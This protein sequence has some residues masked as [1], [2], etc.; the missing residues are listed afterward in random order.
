LA[1]QNILGAPL[2]GGKSAGAPILGT[3]ILL[4]MHQFIERNFKAL[5]LLLLAALVFVL[6]QYSQNGR[7]R[8]VEGE[9][10]P[11]DTHTGE[12]KEDE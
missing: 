10:A 3:Q 12:Y 8:H 2:Y 4:T 5:L 7:Y 6:Y 11:M 1:G 9:T